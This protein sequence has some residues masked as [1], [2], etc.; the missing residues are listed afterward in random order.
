MAKRY[1][2]ATKALDL[3]SFQRDPKLISDYICALPQPRI[4]KSVVNVVSQHQPELEALNLDGNKLDMV[5]HYT[6]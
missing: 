6:S 3:S 1:V 2:P 4:L 5:E